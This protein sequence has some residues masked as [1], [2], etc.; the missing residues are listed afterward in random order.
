M[1]AMCIKCMNPDALVSMDLDGT[2]Q[3]RC[4]ECEEEFGCDEVREALEAMQKGW[5]KLLAWADAYPQ[6]EEAAEAK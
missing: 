4:G 5:A 3:F 2:C 1:K 6:E